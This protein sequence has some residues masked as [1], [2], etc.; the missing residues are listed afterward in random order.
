MTVS[1]VGNDLL[2]DFLEGLLPAD[3]EARVATHLERCATCARARDVL[4]DVGVLL[5]QAGSEP[6]SMP[7]DVAERLDA[8]LAAESRARS[9]ET[10]VVSLHTRDARVA[11]GQHRRPNDRGQHDLGRHDRSR[12]AR[13][14]KAGGWR[15]RPARLLLTAAAS[16][17]V[18]AVGAIAARGILTPDTTNVA[19]GNHPTTAPTTTA[20][21]TPASRTF[22]FKPTSTAPALS[23]D[24]FA[25]E[26]GQLIEARPAGSS[27]T[28]EGFGSSGHD[29]GVA[30]SADRC[31]ERILERAGAGTPLDMTTG[32]LDGR[33]VQVAIVAERGTG[34]V[35][36]Y[37]IEGCPGS[38]ARIAHEAS[39]SLR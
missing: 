3:D 32:K 39:V 38:T 18:L 15:A 17:A 25:A 6:V 28:S 30:P 33:P 8:A 11:R 14:R 37:A 27:P 22:T 16:V 24:G 35:R 2:A 20:P 10:G 12:N 23:T 7:P 31:V 34:G 5:R 13:G 36:A 29:P 26:V 4:V 21:S 9:Q 1:H 19:G